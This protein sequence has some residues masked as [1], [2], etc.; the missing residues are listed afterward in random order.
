MLARNVEVR[1]IVLE[2]TEH[3]AF[4][5]PSLIVATLSQLRKQGFRVALDDFGEGFSNLQFVQAI[6]PDYL[7]LS[8]S[9]C[10]GLPTDRHK[11]IIVQTVVQMARQLSIQTVL[12]HVETEQELHYARKLGI[13]YAQG[14]LFAAALA[15]DK[16]KE[17]L[18]L[19]V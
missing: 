19:C 2:L 7:K 17:A 8:G 6:K 16:L 18:P 5:N 15:P 11:Q 1:N 14:Y 10:R 9:F 12:E 4:I 3:Q 13:D